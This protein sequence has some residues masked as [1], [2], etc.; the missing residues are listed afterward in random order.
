M[1]VPEAVVKRIYVRGSMSNSQSGLVFRLKNTLVS[2]HLTATGAME[3]DGRAVQPSVIM[4]R[5]KEAQV[6]ASDV[7]AE[8]PLSLPAGV[9]L[10][11][12]AEG[13]VLD[14]GRH[15]IRFPVVIREIGPVTL[16]LSDEIR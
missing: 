14:P 10:E 3:I 6:K 12:N 2:G 8:S 1:N 5:T 15:Q 9:E 16:T 13:V 7:S 11:V 4:L